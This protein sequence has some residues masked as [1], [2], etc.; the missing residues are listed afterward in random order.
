VEAVVQVAVV[1]AHTAGT[2]GCNGNSLGCS[3]HGVHVR[4]TPPSPTPGLGAPLS[5]TPGLGLIHRYQRIGFQGGAYG[6]T[7]ARILLRVAGASVM[8]CVHGILHRHLPLQPR[9]H[10][11][12]IS[13]QAR[14]ILDGEAATPVVAIFQLEVEVWQG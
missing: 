3:R 6:S 1:V 10:E 9:P 7:L 5:P 11:P 4:P 13:E 2:G 8:V 14:G 12:K